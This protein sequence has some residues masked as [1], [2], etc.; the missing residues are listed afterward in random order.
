MD[1]SPKQLCKLY[2]KC[3]VLKSMQ[4]PSQEALGMKW[5]EVAMRDVSRRFTERMKIYILS[6][7]FVDG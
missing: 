3:S 6:G 2:S 5:T 1:L 7:R 4:G